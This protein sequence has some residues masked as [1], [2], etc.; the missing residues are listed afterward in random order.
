MNVFKSVGIA[1]A[2][3]AVAGI[4]H[5]GQFTVEA[6]KSKPLRIKGEA[7]SVVIGNPNIA[8]I[9]VHDEHL[10]FISGKTFG[11]TN[12]LIFDKDGKTLYAAD[13]VVT[14]NTSNLVTV[15]RAGRDFSYDCSPTCRAG[16]SIGDDPGHYGEV[17]NQLLQ[18][19][20]LYEE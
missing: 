9:G 13:L 16:L 12:L 20:E 8:D 6:G 1:V 2:S 19:K 17:F 18:Q 7:A 5:A 15:N 4:A 11:T 3:L 14:T 10:L